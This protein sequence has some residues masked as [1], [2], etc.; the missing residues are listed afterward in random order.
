MFVRNASMLFG[1][2]GQTLGIGRDLSKFTERLHQLVDLPGQLC[3]HCLAGKMAV[4]HGE[5][6]RVCGQ[7]LAPLRQLAGGHQRRQAGGGDAV[8]AGTILV[9]RQQ[10][11]QARRDGKSRR[12]KKRQQQ[13]ERYAEAD[14]PPP[15]RRRFG[16]NQ[17]LRRIGDRPG[18]CGVGHG[19]F[20]TRGH[21][22]SASGRNA[23]LPG[24]VFRT[25]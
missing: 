4:G 11:E 9:E 5:V 7:R 15:R 12:A 10:R 6:G 19:D 20:F 1:E 18:R 21:S 24:I 17:R 2:F 14:L 23:S 3:G 22:L 13:P 16:G 25:S 8:K